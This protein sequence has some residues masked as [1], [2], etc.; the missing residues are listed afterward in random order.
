MN[1]LVGTGK[2]TVARIVP[3]EYYKQKRL[4]ADFFLR[5]GRDISYA[6][7]FVAS[8][9]VQLATSVP[10][11]QRHIR[12]AI[13]EDTNIANKGLKTLLKST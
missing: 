6:G 3:Q 8:I 1:G 4:G 9:A 10:T 11:L 5:G 2:S 12:D 7:N 13:S